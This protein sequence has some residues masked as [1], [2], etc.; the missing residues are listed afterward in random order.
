MPVVVAESHAT[1][2]VRIHQEF[3]NDKFDPAEEVEVNKISIGFYFWGW[4]GFAFG[5]E[6]IGG[7]TSN[8]GRVK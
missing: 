5:R 7:G 4:L 8:L 1:N 3:V 2:N 6:E